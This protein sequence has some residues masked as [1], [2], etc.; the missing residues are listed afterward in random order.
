MNHFEGLEPGVSSFISTIMGVMEEQIFFFF[1]IVQYS[2]MKMNN[3]SLCDHLWNIFASVKKVSTPQ[4]W[5]LGN[6]N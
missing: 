2:H 4:T 6:S 5:Y 1:N 3:F